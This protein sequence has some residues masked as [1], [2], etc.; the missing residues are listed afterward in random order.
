MSLIPSD[1]YKLGAQ[2]FIIERKA[3]VFD[4]TSFDDIIAS[5]TGNVTIEENGY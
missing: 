5:T 1:L 3:N 4:S 2:T